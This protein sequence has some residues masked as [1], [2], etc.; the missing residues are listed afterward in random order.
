MQLN[1]VRCNVQSF[2]LFLLIFCSFS[3][4]LSIQITKNQAVITEVHVSDFL[5][6]HNVVTD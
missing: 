3:S 6:T 4:T 1:S 5:S 2:N